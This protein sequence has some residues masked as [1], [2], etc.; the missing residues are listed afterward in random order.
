M[1]TNARVGVLYD[2]RC[3][4]HQNCQKWRFLDEYK[5]CITFALSVLHAYEHQW[6]CQLIYHPCK[7]LHFGLSDG[8]GC[9][10]FWSIIKKLIPSLWVSG[11][12]AVQFL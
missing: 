6:P 4:L 9:E 3:Q 8:E 7:C 12:C 10:W 2:I 1:P 5:D 11:V